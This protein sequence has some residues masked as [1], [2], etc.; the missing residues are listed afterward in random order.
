MSEEKTIL[1]VCEHSYDL[2]PIVMTL[3]DLM[4]PFE[5]CLPRIPFLVSDPLRPDFNLFEM[6]NNIQSI[7][8]G[9]HESAFKDVKERMDEDPENAASIIV[10][11]LRY[12]YRD[13]K[14]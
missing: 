3:F 1:I 13:P 10:V 7:V 5:W 14:L 9:I 4:L 12:T 2:L 8:L 6:I 11:D